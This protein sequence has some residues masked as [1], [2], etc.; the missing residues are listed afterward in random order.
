MCQNKYYYFR[1]ENE[2]NEILDLLEAQGY[3][4]IIGYHRIT[5]KEVKNR[6]RRNKIFVI[7][8][9]YNTLNNKYEYQATTKQILRTY[10]IILK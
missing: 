5:F 2:L 3:K 7:N 6:Y 9:Y 1:T 10:G 8:A 4:P